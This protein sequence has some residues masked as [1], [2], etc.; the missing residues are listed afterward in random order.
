M[1]F[2]RWL[3]VI[4]VAI[5]LGWIGWLVLYYP[6]L[7]LDKLALGIAENS[8]FTRLH[9]ETFGAFGFA[10]G[11]VWGGAYT[12]PKYKNIIAIL[13]AVIMVLISLWS[14]YL[15]YGKQEWWSVYAAGITIIALGYVIFIIR[16]SSEDAELFFTNLPW[17]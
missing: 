12:A 14:M 13:L 16:T 5:I 7:W 1:K 11:F 6:N 2:L 4:P 9:I 10:L 17:N 3:L 15:G 8:F